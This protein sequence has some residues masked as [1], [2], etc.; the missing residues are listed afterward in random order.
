M[1][2]PSQKT[3]ELVAEGCRWVVILGLTI[4]GLMLVIYLIMNAIRQGTS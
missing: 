2:Y 3:K 4:L 1:F